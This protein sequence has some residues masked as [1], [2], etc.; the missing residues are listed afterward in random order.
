MSANI[1]FAAVDEFLGGSSCVKLKSQVCTCD[2]PDWMFNFFGSGPACV[3][4]LESQFEGPGPCYIFNVLILETTEELEG[5]SVDLVKGFKEP[6]LRTIGKI[7]KTEDDQIFLKYCSDLY[8]LKKPEK[9]TPRT[10]QFNTP[11]RDDFSKFREIIV[12]HYGEEKFDHKGKNGKNGYQCK[13]ENEDVTITLYLGTLKL[14]I[15]GRG[16][17]QWIIGTFNHLVKQLY[18]EKKQQKYQGT[19]F[20]EQQLA[21]PQPIHEQIS[22]QR[23]QQPNF[24]HQLSPRSPQLHLMS[25]SPEQFQNPPSPTSITSCHQDGQSQQIQQHPHHSH[26]QPIS[27]VTPQPPAARTSQPQENLTNLQLTTPKTPLVT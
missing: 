8:T 17:E 20:R 6:E 9:I 23:S 11:K 25:Q 21:T 26:E 14:F 15:Q 13:S 18:N 4:K 24:G 12:K 22:G 1:H 2:G 7:P 19:Q 3:F 5:Y 27:Y 16:C 10:I